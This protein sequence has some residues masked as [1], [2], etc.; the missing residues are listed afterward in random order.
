MA[1]PEKMILMSHRVPQSL[2]R[3]LRV[4]AALRETTVQ[5]LIIEAV[6][7]HLT[8]KEATK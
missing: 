2:H 7:R 4:T 3:K 6:Q 1:K 5:A 8:G